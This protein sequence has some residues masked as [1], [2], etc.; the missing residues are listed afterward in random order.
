MTFSTCH[1]TYMQTIQTNDMVSPTWHLAICPISR[2]QSSAAKA[3]GN[4]PHLHRS[5]Q[6][7]TVHN[8]P[9]TAIFTPA[10]RIFLDSQALNGSSMTR[11]HR[12]TRVEKPISP[13]HAYG[14]IR[15]TAE[16]H[17]IP[18]RRQAENC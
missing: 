17:A 2:F 13:P 3:V 11:Q 6:A 15:R 8:P 5:V 7:T 9:P 12:Y 16:Y 4:P 1:D 18:G 14:V 10:A